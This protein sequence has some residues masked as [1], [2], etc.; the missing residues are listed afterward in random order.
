LKPRSLR[1][2]H[3][4]SMI[5]GRPLASQALLLERIKLDAAETARFH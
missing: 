5:G 4:S 3:L 2:S 1:G